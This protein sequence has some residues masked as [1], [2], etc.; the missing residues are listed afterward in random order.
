MGSV[1]FSCAKNNNDKVGKDASTSGSPQLLKEPV[2][3]I[4]HGPL[5]TFLRF[6]VK[7]GIL[8]YNSGSEQHVFVG[9]VR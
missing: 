3:F 7:I 1:A 8:G 4:S 9:S 5:M 2:E 6:K